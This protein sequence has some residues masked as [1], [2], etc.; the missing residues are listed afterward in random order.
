ME[1]TVSVIHFNPR[2]SIILMKYSLYMKMSYNA[3]H[4]LLEASWIDKSIMYYLK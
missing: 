2:K 3:V 1:S 4:F